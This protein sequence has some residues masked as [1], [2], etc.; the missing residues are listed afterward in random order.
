MDNVFEVNDTF[1][2]CNHN[3]SVNYSEVLSSDPYVPSFIDFGPAFLGLY[4]F[5]NVDNLIPHGRTDGHLTGFLP[6]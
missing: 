5:E 1:C 2:V 4:G 3:F 6:R